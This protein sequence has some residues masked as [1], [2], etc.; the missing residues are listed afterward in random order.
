M[1]TQRPYAPY[2]PDNL[3]FVA[4]NN[5]FSESEL[6]KVFLEGEGLVVVVVG[7]YCGNSV[8]VPVDPRQR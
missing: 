8:A 4:E 2:L 7:F 1:E 6:K 3:R 5:A